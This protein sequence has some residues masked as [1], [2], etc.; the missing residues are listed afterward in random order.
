MP[1]WGGRGGVLT[2]ART[3]FSAPA[4]A[5]PPARHLRCARPAPPARP[6]QVSALRFLSQKGLANCDFLVA[7]TAVCTGTT[8]LSSLVAE[9]PPQQPVSGA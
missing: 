2:N 7:S 4:G 3:F 1:R 5:M 9:G 6:P 8:L